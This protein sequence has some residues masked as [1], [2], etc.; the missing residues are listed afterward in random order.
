MKPFVLHNVTIP[1]RAISQNTKKFT[2]IVRINIKITIHR[3]LYFKFQITISQANAYGYVQDNKK[4]M[5]K[6]LP[7]MHQ[8]CT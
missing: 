3:I 6:I 1:L 4:Q 7:D 8:Y 2:I 5:C